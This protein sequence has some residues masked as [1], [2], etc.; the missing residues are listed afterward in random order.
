M[1]KYNDFNYFLK[2]NKQTLSDEAM[3]KNRRNFF[4]IID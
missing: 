2:I 1:L 3:N 4:N